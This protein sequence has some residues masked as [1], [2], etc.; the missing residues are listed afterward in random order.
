MV[1][2]IELRGTRDGINF[3]RTALKHREEELKDAEVLLRE[4]RQLYQEAIRSFLSIP[5]GDFLGG[6]GESILQRADEHGVNPQRLAEEI[7]MRIN[8]ARYQFSFPPNNKDIL[9]SPESTTTPDEA[10]QLVLYLIR[11]EPRYRAFGNLVYTCLE[12][13]AEL[14]KQQEKPLETVVMYE[15]LHD[16]HTLLWLPDRDLK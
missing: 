1:D 4:T 13:A 3:F 14:S 12:R 16:H 2:S 11:H 7:R 5:K 15:W 10:F 6:A 9:K 8:Q